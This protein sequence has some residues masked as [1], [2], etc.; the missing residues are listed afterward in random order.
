MLL[1]SRCA[2]RHQVVDLCGS[3]TWPA[4]GYYHCCASDE[5]IWGQLAL[6]NCICGVPLC[7]NPKTGG[8]GLSHAS[9]VTN[10]TPRL[11]CEAE[12]YV[13]YF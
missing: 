7:G 11:K 2:R 1:N 9:Y 3:A 13:V 5:L 8:I 4:P 6:L 12:S 10:G